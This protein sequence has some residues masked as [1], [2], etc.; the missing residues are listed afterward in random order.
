MPSVLWD[1]ASDRNG[2]FLQL[3]MPRS[4]VQ[5]RPSSQPE[6]ECNHSIGRS[7]HSIGTSL[8]RETCDDIPG[9][10]TLSVLEAK[11]NHLL[12]AAA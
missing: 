9:S 10:I 7:G 11:K 1:D 4:Q 6:L 12:S 5:C 2:L 8:H 3:R